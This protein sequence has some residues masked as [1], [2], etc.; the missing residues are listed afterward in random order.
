MEERTPSNKYGRRP[1]VLYVTQ[2]DVAPPTIVLFVNRAS[3][4]TETYQRFMV[5]R[6]RELLPYA[7]VPI[8]LL[9][10][11]RSSAA[12][13]G[14]SETPRPAATPAPKG[15]AKG[16]GSKAGLARAKSLAKSREV[17]AARKKAAAAAKPPKPRGRGPA[18][19]PSR[20]KKRGKHPM[21]HRR[22]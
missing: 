21:N 1:K 3:Y 19:A 20:G 8:K 10:R 4:L 9:I 18:P 7:E 16:G 15:A 5:N 6:F 14:T 22:R 12:K 17:E 11:E 13:V 2:T